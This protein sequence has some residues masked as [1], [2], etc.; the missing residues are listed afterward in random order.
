MCSIESAQNRNLS[1]SRRVLQHSND[2][3]RIGWRTEKQM[4]NLF[5][6]SVANFEIDSMFDWRQNHLEMNPR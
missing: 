2:G 1:A 4:K 3:Q 6:Y 5:R